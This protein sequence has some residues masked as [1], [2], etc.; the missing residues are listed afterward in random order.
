MENRFLRAVAF[1][2]FCGFKAVTSFFLFSFSWIF[3]N[4]DAPSQTVG[5]M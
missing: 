5:G 4:M 3:S 1:E 2:G